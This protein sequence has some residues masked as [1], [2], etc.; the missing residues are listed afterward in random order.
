MPS[1]RM[2]KDEE[3]VLGVEALIENWNIPFVGNQGL[4][5]ISTAKDAPVDMSSDLLHN[6]GI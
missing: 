4:N 6:C 1:P 5:S 2:P 3:Q